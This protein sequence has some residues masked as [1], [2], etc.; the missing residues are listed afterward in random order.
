MHPCRFEWFKIILE[1]NPGASEVMVWAGGVP[2]PLILSA[3][4]HPCWEA[5]LKHHPNGN[6][7]LQV[8]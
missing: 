8:K 1:H 5:P 4:G 3:L 2:V 6:W 7:T